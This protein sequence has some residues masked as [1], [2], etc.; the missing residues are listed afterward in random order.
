[1]FFQYA[2]Y[3]FLF[4]LVPLSIY[5]FLKSIKNYNLIIKSY[6][7]SIKLNKN[8]RRQKNIIAVMIMLSM[9]LLI[10]AIMQPKWGR[11]KETIKINSY[12]IS[13]VIDLSESMNAKD[14]SP[15]RL[16]KTKLEINKFVKE[17]N[18]ITVS[19]VGFAGSSFIASPLTQDT[20]TFSIILNALNTDS[21]TLQGT[22]IATALMTSIKSFPETHSLPRSIIIIT[23]GEDHTG[24][25]DN[26]VKQ[27]KNSDISL[28]AVAIGNEAGEYIPDKK[29]DMGNNILSKRTD[30]IL[31]S[32]V[33]ETR[34]KFYVSENGNIPF[35]EIYREIEKNGNVSSIK[36]TMSYKNRFQFFLLPVV[37]LLLIVAILMALV[38][39]DKSEQ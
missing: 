23:D 12:N 16:E 33:N 27:L 25:F 14:I 19:L 21:V 15:S 11:E 22:S 6:F 3:A 35:N 39:K 26:V 4:L 31:S 18:N 37:I 36:N 13:I 9:T 17:N 29:D 7:N 28:Y 5:L 30:N 20:E 34:G 1:M 8:A 24:D 32:L 2:Y 10:I 38:G